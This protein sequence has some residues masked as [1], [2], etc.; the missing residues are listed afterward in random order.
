VLTSLWEGFGY[1]LVEAMAS[2]KPVV[3]FHI[4]SNPEIV[5]H[6]ETGYLVELR[7]MESMADK[8]RQLAGNAPLREE[9]GKKGRSRVEELFNLNRNQDALEK[10]LQELQDD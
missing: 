5:Q 8:I 7:D 3:A 2:R 9:M 6:D 10:F 4:S 1:V